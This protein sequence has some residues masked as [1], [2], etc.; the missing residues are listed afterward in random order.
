M[1]LN[2]KVNPR[3]DLTEPADRQD[4]IVCAPARDNCDIFDLTVPSEYLRFDVAKQVADVVA[5]VV[6]SYSN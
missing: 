3:I 5:V 6:A 2:N 1:I 4:G